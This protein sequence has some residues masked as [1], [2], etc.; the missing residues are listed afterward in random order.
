MAS[1]TTS[2]DS[3]LDLDDPLCRLPSVAGGKAAGLSR[4]RSAGLPA[5]KG[6]VVSTRAAAPTLRAG[7]AALAIR[8][9]GSARLVAMAQPM[10]DSL[11][12]RLRAAVRELG[13]DVIV[14][15][16]ADVESG[17]E[18]SGAFST[19]SEVGV[20]DVATA[21]R[22]CWASAF[23]VD[24]IERGERV[25]MSP[26]DMAVAVLVQPRIEPRAS[27]LAR[28]FRDSVEIEA[29]SGSP[30]A[31]MA[32][33]ATGERIVVG[34]DD[35]IIAPPPSLLTPYE[36]V[37]VARLAIL[38]Q[39]R[40]GHRVIEWAWTDEG[41][42][43]LQSLA[44]ERPL[45][46]DPVP[47]LPELAHPEAQ[48]VAKLAVTFPGGVCDELVFPWALGIRGQV[49]PTSADSGAPL[50]FADTRREAEAAARAVWPASP[51]PIAECRRFL[52]ELRG[53]APGL[54]LERLA[55]LGTADL[56][57]A[58]AVLGRMAAAGRHAVESGWLLDRD[59]VFGLELADVSSGRPPTPRQSWAGARRWE[60]FLAGVAQA[61]GSA[62]AASPA[63]PGV[64]AGAA[65]VVTDAHQPGAGRRPRQVI[66]APLP[67]PALSS[68]LWDAAG[69][70][71]TGGSAGAHLIE[72]AR[73]LGV[74]AVVRCTD[75]PLRQLTSDT[76]VAVDGDRG[77]A[78]WL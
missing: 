28:A 3:V 11:A 20:D 43:L 30:A 77:L 16:S 51:D 22:G 40:L 26:D 10:Q 61:C 64:G 65:R 59:D 72:V 41:L 42:V 46:A 68:L 35:A 48:R 25:G 49:T 39:E 9:S 8:G 34:P 74:P 44:A 63:A 56:R 70:V 60:P 6:V 7:A 57:L 14:R 24:V 71:T 27:G 54:A 58:T 18:W 76:I 73:S 38:T 45:T 5:L 47:S 75:L 31:L 13:G 62:A 36:A 50:D 4:A 29:V 53:P 17:A 52:Q 21:V 37:E 15:S 32:G 55:A 78:S 12:E 69:L 19:F 33:W 23:A 67:V 1:T 66:V 2:V